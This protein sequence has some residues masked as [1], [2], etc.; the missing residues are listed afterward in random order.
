MQ[1]HLLTLIRMPVRATRGITPEARGQT[2]HL[3]LC[4]VIWHWYI[5][6]N[7]LKP[8]RIETLRSIIDHLLMLI[9]PM[10]RLLINWLRM[11]VLLMV[12]VAHLGITLVI[13][14]VLR[15]TRVIGIVLLLRWH[16]KCLVMHFSH[17]MVLLRCGDLGPCQSLV[18]HR[19]CLG[20]ILLLLLTWDKISRLRVS[21]LSYRLVEL[22][23]ESARPQLA[24]L[25]FFI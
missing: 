16:L 18:E 22:L 19:L 14:C 21:W 6:S 2:G 23:V 7:T 13:L 20:Q 9:L 10:N 24:I 3:P 25:V 1:R 15:L 12:S 8:A 4:L 17:S 5:F 11:N